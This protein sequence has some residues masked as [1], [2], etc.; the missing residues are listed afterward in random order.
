MKKESPEEKRRRLIMLA[1]ASVSQ[2]YS[3]G[4]HSVMQAIGSYNESERIRNLLHEKLEEWYGIYFPE[5][6]LSN[7]LSY[8]RFVAEFGMNKKSIEMERLE[9]L[10]GEAS[11]DVL[12]RAGTSIG[13]EP[14][15]KEFEMLR[16]LANAELQMDEL[17][18][19]LDRYLDAATKELM[20]NIVYLIDY[21]I[22]AELLAKAGS[23]TRLANMPAGTIQ[24]LGAEKALFKHIKFHSKPP[25]YG[26]LY[27]LPQINT[28]PKGD[29]G[30]MARVYATKISIAARADAYSKNFI[31]KK[32]KEQL[33]KAL[34]R[35]HK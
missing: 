10:L 3:T 2:A 14:T 11:K 17:Q 12:S 19:G 21:K 34:K 31:A 13:R 26:V 7:Q 24:L 28:A 33:D 9:R 18:Q 25:K 15:E 23:L 8:A 20:P 4:E 16:S 29:R 32:L 22:A 27:K 30:R 35:H 6:K 1:K 5:L